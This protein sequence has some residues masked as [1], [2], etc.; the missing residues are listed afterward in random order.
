MH[1]ASLLNSAAGY[2]YKACWSRL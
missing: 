2:D 1:R